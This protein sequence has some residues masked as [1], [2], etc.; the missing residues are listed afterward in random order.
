MIKDLADRIS[1]PFMAGDDRG[2][3]PSMMGTFYEASGKVK[4]LQAA[5][6]PGIKLQDP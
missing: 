5:L 1:T 6:Y 3:L 2:M 4:S